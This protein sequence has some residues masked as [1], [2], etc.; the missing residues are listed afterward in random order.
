MLTDFT[1]T[2]TPTAIV[3]VPVI[4]STVPSKTEQIKYSTVEPHMEFRAI[5]E[6]YMQINQ[7]WRNL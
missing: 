5:V 2:K 7:S 4:S 3:W 6:L 1:E